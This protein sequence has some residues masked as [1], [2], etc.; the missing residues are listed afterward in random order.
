MGKRKPSIAP[1][2]AE[3]D[4]AEE[5]YMVETVPLLV[6]DQRNMENHPHMGKY[7]YMDTTDTTLIFIETDSN[8]IKFNG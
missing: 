4:A 1:G 6:S 5:L 3:G 7:I 2:E 8:W